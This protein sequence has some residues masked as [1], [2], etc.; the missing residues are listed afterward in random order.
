MAMFKWKKALCASVL[1][2]VA[3][4][5]MGAMGLDMNFDERILF[6][7]NAEREALGIEPLRWNPALAQSAQYW[8]TSLAVSGRF[9]HAPADRANPVGENLWA[10]TKGYYSPEAM[11][12]AWAREKQNFRPGRFPA[13]SMTGNVADVGHYTQMVWRTTQEV[14]CAR[15][16]G[17]REDILVCRYT[18]AGNFLGQR[19][20]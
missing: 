20:F 2:L 8:A 5:N 10:G 14:G 19:P 11:V 13:N 7:H 17:T 18:Q 16:T 1:G 12:Q 4:F 6:A 15:A 9:Q 3:P